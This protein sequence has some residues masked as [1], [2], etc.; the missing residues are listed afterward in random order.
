LF[1]FGYGLTYTTFRYSQLHGRGGARLGVDFDITNTGRRPGTEVAQLYVAPPGRTHRLAGWAR[2]ELRP[3][4]TRRVSIV[5][6]PRLLESYGASGWARARPIRH[7][8]FPGCRGERIARDHRPVGSV[9]RNGPDAAGAAKL[10]A[11]GESREGRHGAA[12][13]GH[14]RSPDQVDVEALGTL[15]IRGIDRQSREDEQGANRQE[16]QAQGQSDIQVHER[17]LSGI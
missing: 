1:A 4:E 6:D 12:E 11:S 13:R 3:G 15:Q 2:V 16:E 14:R 5:A 10:A 7:P 9:A 17:L 8:G